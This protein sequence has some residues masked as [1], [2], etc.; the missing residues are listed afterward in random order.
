[1]VEEAGAPRAAT[2]M[3]IDDEPS[4]GTG[5]ELPVLLLLVVFRAY[6]ALVPDA[7]DDGL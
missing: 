1:M 3:N 7:V 6:V 5:E 4:T 2:G